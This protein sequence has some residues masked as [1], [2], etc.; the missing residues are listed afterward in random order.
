MWRPRI[1]RKS[2][3]LYQ[4]L[5][6]AIAHDVLAG[7]LKGGDRLPPH[8]ELADTLGITVTTVT[9][10]YAEA[11]RRGLVRG[12]VGRGTF[13]NPPAFPPIAAASESSV[14]LATNALLPHVHAAEL[15][16]S[17]ALLVTRSTP[18]FLFN[19]QPHGGRPEHRRLAAAW[20]GRQ[21]VPATAA[22]TILTSGAQHAMTVALATLTTPGD[23]VLCESVTYTGM[24]SLANHL[25]V[26]AHPVAM[27]GE[28]LLPDALE[29]AALESGARVLYCVPSGQ[30]PT[31]RVMSKKRRQEIVRVAT[32][33]DL[34]IVEDD[35]YGFLF[36][37][38]MSLCAASP[39]RTFYLTSLSKSV[40]PGLRIGLLRTPP[41]WTERVVG[42]VFATTVMVTP[43]DAAAACAWLDDGTA[44]RVMAWKREEARARQQIARQILGDAI[45]GSAESQHAWLQ[46]NAAWQSDDFAREARQRGVM[47][48]PA[49]DFAVAR[50]DVPNAVRLA[51]GAPPDRDTLKKGLTTLAAILD[52]PPQPFGMTV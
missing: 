16:E 34:M 35:A 42:A 28:G 39:E 40:A 2:G 31:A 17:L 4:S 49:R 48:S 7:K 29:D 8:R 38:A 43:L 44:A 9:R 14:D 5:A 20:L 10:G 19:Y 47:V 23:A 50:H 33:L 21:Q 30:N 13:V 1:E 18:E 52:E 32:R 11:E 12:E 3:P 37:G 45:T 6:A 26:R 36:D 24:R 22:N 51:L 27:D 15:T 25:H 46:V 41:G